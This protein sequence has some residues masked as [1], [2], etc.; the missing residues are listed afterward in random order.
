MAS[1]SAKGIEEIIKEYINK[2]RALLLSQ[3]EQN[4]Y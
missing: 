2:K 3:L 4:G 1:K